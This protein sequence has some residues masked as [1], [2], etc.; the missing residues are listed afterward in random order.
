MTM[1]KVSE[2]QGKHTLLFTF[3]NSARW[4]AWIRR[5][6]VLCSVLFTQRIY[7]WRNPRSKK[8]YW[9]KTA[10]Y[11]ITAWGHTKARFEERKAAFVCAVCL[12]CEL[13]SDTRLLPAVCARWAP[14]ARLSYSQRYLPIP[15]DK[16]II[17]SASPRVRASGCVWCLLLVS[18]WEKDGGFEIW[19]AP[20]VYSLSPTASPDRSLVWSFPLCT[21]QQL[22]NSGVCP[23]AML[24]VS[25]HVV[26][27]C[28]QGAKGHF[29]MWLREHMETCSSL[30]PTPLTRSWGDRK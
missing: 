22:G 4:G 15:A 6:S 17:C 9:A 2:S 21:L 5:G 13:L 30:I 18:W 28:W 3:L 23:S 29:N 24:C 27:V 19:S 26:L 25:A 20:C 10:C 1:W 14:S 7:M 8:F 16:T 12:V 11:L